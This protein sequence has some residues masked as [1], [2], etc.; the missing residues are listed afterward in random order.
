MASLKIYNSADTCPIGLF[1][2]VQD[3]SDLRWLIILPQEDYFSG[4]LPED[5]TENDYD[6]L[7]SKFQDIVGSFPDIALNKEKIQQ[8]FRLEYLKFEILIC[9][10]E[11]QKARLQNKLNEE[12]FKRK[13][14]EKETENIENNNIKEVTAIETGL[15]IQIDIFKCSIAKYFNYRDAYNNIIKQQSSKNKRNGRK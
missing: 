7:A 9:D 6:L 4:Q 10:N 8:D 5:L 14:K 12:L 13:L 1:W 2:K 3:T 15:N 11:S